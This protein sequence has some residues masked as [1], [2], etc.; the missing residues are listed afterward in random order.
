[1]KTTL[2]TYI[3]FKSFIINSLKYDYN[4]GSSTWKYDGSSINTNNM[5][6]QVIYYKT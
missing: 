4:N 1:M 6:I 2:K 5:N 3:K